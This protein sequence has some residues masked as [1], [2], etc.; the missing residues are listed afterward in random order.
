[1]F[2]LGPEW[3]A[4]RTTKLRGIVAGDLS[5]GQRGLA[6]RLAWDSRVSS[7][8]AISREEEGDGSVDRQRDP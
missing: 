3:L 7:Q 2:W 4:G 5:E 1:M 8:G 6:G